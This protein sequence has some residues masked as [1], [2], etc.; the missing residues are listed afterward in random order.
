MISAMGRGAR[1]KSI[2]NAVKFL[3]KNFA[4]LVSLKKL[5]GIAELSPYHFTRVFAREMGLPP[6]A[7]QVKLR[8]ER[9]KELIESGMAISDIAI[10]TGFTDQSH[11]TRHFKKRFGTLPSRYK[12]GLRNRAKFWRK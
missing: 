9:A 7:Y 6:H 1:K 12:A 11:L 4:V 2:T 8:L 3:E 10:E 5:A